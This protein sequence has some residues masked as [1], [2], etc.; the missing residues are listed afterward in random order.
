MSAV[1]IGSVIGSLLAQGPGDLSSAEKGVVTVIY[2]C[3]NPRSESPDVYPTPYFLL[4]KG[5]STGILNLRKR[6]AG[7]EEKRG[8]EKRRRRGGRKKGRGLYRSI[9]LYLFRSRSERQTG[10]TIHDPVR[11]LL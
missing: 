9:L 3:C 6:L 7:R 8:R 10:E 11:L 2:G 1:A 5:P 4:L